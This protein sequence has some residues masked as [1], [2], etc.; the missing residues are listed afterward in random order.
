MKLL[1]LS[2]LPM[3]ATGAVITSGSLSP[4]LL[5][6]GQTAAAPITS[7]T[8]TYVD[9]GIT[10]NATVSVVGAG[11]L[12]TAGGL[13]GVGDN[14]FGNGTTA[15]L[16]DAEL[17]NGEQY[18]ISFDQ[19]VEIVS[20]RW[21]GAAGATDTAE[22]LINGGNS[23]LIGGANGTAGSGVNTYAAPV[24]LAAGDLIT[25]TGNG[26]HTQGNSQGSGLFGD[27]T[28]NAIQ[29]VP[30]P[31]SAALLGLGGLALVARRR[32]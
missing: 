22:I 19:D 3:I 21:S 26:P 7:A 14:T 12:E 24:F 15:G 25:V 10:V 2:S 5:T 11:G 31:S 6:S 32:R 30:E 13:I 29:Q 20:F 27:W 9:N 1:I 4:S 17:A 16:A 8:G 28:F 23:T 18:T